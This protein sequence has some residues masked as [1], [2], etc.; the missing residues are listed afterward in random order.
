[1]RHLLAATSF[2]FTPLPAYAHL[3]H[4]GELAGHGHWVALGAGLTAAMLAALLAKKKREAELQ[5]DEEETQDDTAG[6]PAG[7]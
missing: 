6:E 4:F 3:G 5:A 7:A 1:M 2:I